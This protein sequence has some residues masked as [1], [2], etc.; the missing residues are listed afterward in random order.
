MTRIY[1]LALTYEEAKDYIRRQ[2]DNPVNYIILNRPEQ[3]LGTINPKVVFTVNAYR[4]P[5]Y[6][7]F[8]DTYRTRLR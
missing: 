6:N 8:F 4:R 7:E 2:K 3:L 5:D 1:V